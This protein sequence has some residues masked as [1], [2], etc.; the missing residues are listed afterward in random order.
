M[1]AVELDRALAIGSRLRDRG[2]DPMKA[3][4][5]WLAATERAGDRIGFVVAGDLAK[6]ARILE[7]EHAS[8]DRIV[9]LVWSSITEEVLAVRGRVEGW[10]AA[11]AA[12]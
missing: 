5:Q 7:R 9:D 10:S 6:C 3:S 12:S 11:R 4:I 8:E 1:H 2:I